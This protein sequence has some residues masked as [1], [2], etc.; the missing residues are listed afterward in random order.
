MGTIN[1]AEV[2]YAQRDF[3]VVAPGRFADLVLVSNLRDFT[4]DTVIFG[5]TEVFR[6]GKFLIEL[7]KTTYPDFMRGTVKLPKP[8]TAEGLTFRVDTNR[9]DNRSASD[10]GDRRKPRKQTSAG[11]FAVVNGTCPRTSK[12]DV[13]LLAMVDR[14]GKGTGTGLD[15]VQGF[16]LR[17]GAIASTANAVCENIV[18]VG[19][20]PT[21]MAVAANHLVSIGGG[22]A[23]CTTATSSHPSSYR[24]AD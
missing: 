24:S 19:T 21:D 14:F 12:K 15:F 13:L 11:R 5:G 7:P 4:I 6:Q 22:K 3:G 2:F 23:W 16:Q 9:R 18:I 10:R 17:D 1:T 20:N 8:M